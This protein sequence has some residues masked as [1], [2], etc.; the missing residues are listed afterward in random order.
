MPRKADAGGAQNRTK[1]QNIQDL[2]E[3]AGVSA[4]TVSRALAGTGK[5]SART[6]ARIRQLA[7]ELGFQPSTMA[8]NLRTGRTGTIGVVVPLGH[9]QTQHI[10]DP[11]FMTLLGH[12]ADHL[13]DRGYDLLL[14]RVVPSDPSWL[15]RLVAA[16]R[17]DGMLIIGQSNQAAVLDRVAQTYRPMVVWGARIEGQSA[18]SVGSDNRLGGRLAADHL[19]SLGCRKMAFFGDPAVPEVEQ[20]LA[21]FRDALRDAGNSVIGAMLPVHFVPELA[22]EAIS[23]FVDMAENLDGVF[24][25][26]DTIAMMAIQALAERGR[27]IP[28]DVKVVGFDDLE[29]ARRTLPPLSSVRQDLAAGAKAMVDLLFRRI[30]GEDTPSVTLAPSLSVRGSTVRPPDHG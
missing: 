9:E 18:C 10:S 28:G 17:T 20:R 26:S 2:A 19:L 3:I 15:D 11:F 22:F 6:R 21:G 7:D 16:G 30:G 8:R 27:S 23:G 25:A 1:P 14:S 13:A 12:I 29:I 4:A 5:V 24:A